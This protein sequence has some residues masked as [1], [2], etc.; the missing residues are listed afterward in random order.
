MTKPRKRSITIRPAT[1]DDSDFILSLMP[2]F[3]AF[4]LPRG[5]RKHEVVAAIRGDVQRALHGSREG[6]HFFVADDTNREPIGFLHLQ[7]QRDFFSGQRTCHVSD[8]AVAAGQ[9][10]RGIGRK[11]ID[12]SRQWAKQHRCR[13][14]TL[15]V[16]PG[17]TRARAL[18]ES[19]GFVPDLLRMVK[20]VR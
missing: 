6:D 5:R 1:A 20:P 15:A 14:L 2:R 19:S 17:N 11:L 18:Y 9:E 8:I 3:V 13:L 4:D 16:F 10:G 7:I 12:H